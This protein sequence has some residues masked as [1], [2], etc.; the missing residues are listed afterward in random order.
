M[1]EASLLYKAIQLISQSAKL[2][3]QFVPLTL[4]RIGQ[5]MA[6]HIRH[7]WI[8]PLWAVTAGQAEPWYLPQLLN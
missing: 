7:A 2:T 6:A 4:V 5:H 8:H 3:G 1:G